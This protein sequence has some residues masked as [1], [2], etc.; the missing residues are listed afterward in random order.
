MF[1]KCTTTT[2]AAIGQEYS[3][4]ESYKVSVSDVA[5][6]SKFQRN[7]RINGTNN[8]YMKEAEEHVHSHS[9]ITQ[10]FPGKDTLLLNEFAN[11]KSVNYA[12]RNLFKNRI[13]RRNENEPNN[14]TFEGKYF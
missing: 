1:T 14:V 5:L 3:Y 10:S 6:S 7:A 8:G 4:S 13:L 12:T 9:E 11:P 2:T